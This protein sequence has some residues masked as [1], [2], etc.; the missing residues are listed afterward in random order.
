MHFLAYGSS[1]LL[2]SAIEGPP[3][4][5]TERERA[6]KA[7]PR[8]LGVKIAFSVRDL[9][10]TYEVFKDWGCEITTEPMAEFW[11]VRLFTALDPAGYEW[12]ITQ[13][14]EEM[15]PEQGAEAVKEAWS[16]G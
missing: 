15:T 9:D 4:P 8:G 13:T 12:Q 14:I 6:I 10:A 2:V 7:G 5:D 11:G 3:Y 16:L 1:M